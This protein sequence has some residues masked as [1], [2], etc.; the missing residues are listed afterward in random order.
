MLHRDVLSVNMVNYKIVLE[1]GTNKIK[2]SLG[3]D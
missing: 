1:I 3:G 2:K